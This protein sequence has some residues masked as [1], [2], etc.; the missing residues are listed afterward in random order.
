MTRLGAELLAGKNQHDAM[1]KKEVR[2]SYIS[3]IQEA[4]YAPHRWVFGENKP[5][6]TQSPRGQFPFFTICQMTQSSLSVKP[7]KS[8]PLSSVRGGEP[9]PKSVTAGCTEISIQW[10]YS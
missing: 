4:L 9:L 5:V 10:F 2:Y 6:T 7:S 8:R 1:L 3:S